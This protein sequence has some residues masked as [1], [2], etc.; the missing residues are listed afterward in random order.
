MKKLL[1]LLFVFSAA[2][3]LAQDGPLLKPARVMFY[4]VE[5]LF[6]TIN[7]P[8]TK[9]EEF[10]PSARANWNTEKYQLKLNHL[11]AVI[12]SA[13]DT[14]QPLAIGL[15]EVENKKVLED[16]VAQPA[17]K[18]FNLGIIHH[19]SPDERGIDVAFLYN[20]DIA[21][22]VFDATLKV[23]LAEDK[24]RDILYFQAYL[25][26]EFPVWFFVNHWPSR[27]EKA[28]EA[29][30]M[31]ASNLLKTKIENI[32]LGD[33]YARIIVMGDF[34]D[35]PTN[36]SVQNLSG[37]DTKGQPLPMQDLM[38]PL[39]DGKSFT[40]RYKDA[41]DMFDQF[42]VSKNL[43]NNTNQYFVRDSKAHIYKPDWL[44]Y[45][46]AKYGPIPDRTYA[47]GKWVGGYSDHLPVYFDVVFK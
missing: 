2:V 3:A 43:L 42:V 13:F 27:R 6:D 20:K 44:L 31:V 10:L 21:E 45:N 25:T 17:L 39:F 5:N 34:N 32:L 24:T 38:V 4:N 46:H 7:D 18:K 8:E 41:N 11:A 22:M 26:E 29:K 14:V 40:V 9:D 23:E 19:N 1:L 37:N 47:S 30:R 16:L 36:A 28:N 12:A 15:A 35:N 33:P